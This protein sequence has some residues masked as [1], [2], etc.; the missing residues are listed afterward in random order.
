MDLRSSQSEKY[1]YAALAVAALG[2]RLIGLGHLP[3]SEAEAGLALQSA[4]KIVGDVGAVPSQ[5]GYEALTRM[6]FVLFGTGDF[7]A[8]FWPAVMGSLLVITPYYFK[9]YLGS[10]EA[11]VLAAILVFDP[12]GLVLSRQA[13]G[14]MLAVSGL[15][16]AAANLG[17]KHYKSAG[18][19]LGIAL[20][21]GLSVWSGLIIIL[22]SAA[23]L[24]WWV[25]PGKIKPILLDYLKS[26]GRELLL[27]TLGSLLLIGTL[28]FL[29]PT[30][31]G[32]LGG[33]LGDL[34][35]GFASPEPFSV[36]VMVI[37]ALSYYFPGL[38]LGI[39][40]GCV[41]IIRKN[42]TDQALLVLLAVSLFWIIFFPGR[43]VGDL[44][45]LAIPLW[46]LSARR[47][48]QL[49][50]IPRTE[51]KSVFAHVLLIVVLAGFIWL[52]LSGYVL[53][54]G[55]AGSEK[56]R[57]AAII[58]SA[59]LLILT[60]VLVGW[61]WTWRVAGKALAL[62]FCFVFTV[63]SLGASLRAA[64]LGD[65][66]CNEPWRESP[67]FVGADRMLRT[68]QDASEW[69]FRSRN[70][71]DIR[72][73]GTQPD[74]LL[75]SLRSF[76]GVNQSLAASSLNQPSILITDK[77]EIN[78]PSVGYLGQDFV[79]MQKVDWKE[80]FGKNYLEW[81]VK[82]KVSSEDDMVILWVR[83]DLFPGSAE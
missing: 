20:L 40:Q 25:M 53:S 58:I 10:K 77:D 39:W 16:L 22:V 51:R 35:G 2:V 15:A 12:A 44:I 6:L 30:N 13:G 74:A 4:G 3:L 36:Q 67:C 70:G 57:L 27:F 49:I 83:S 17:S 72:L 64:G 71:I 63:Y 8:R 46:A 28:F 45:W 62:G 31:L 50:N 66:P 65:N 26:G 59:V 78:I 14:D 29:Y 73:V 69:N 41:G 42:K 19:W 48:I 56:N 82:S 18:F 60:T 24:G 61:G 80:V 11:L 21:G 81:L 54:I 7:L 47:I 76:P 33:S 52:N 32:R 5:P 68:I 1:V 43:S 55:N 34:L 9:N 75:W 79:I 37:V 38:L 23:M